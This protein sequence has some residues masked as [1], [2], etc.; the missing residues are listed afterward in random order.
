MVAVVC[1][2]GPMDGLRF[3][4]EQPPQVY[5]RQEDGGV[6]LRD[7]EAADGAVRMSF[8]S[9]ELLARHPVTIGYALDG[10]TL[11]EAAAAVAFL[12]L[13]GH[14]DHAPV[15]ARV[16]RGGRVVGMQSNPRPR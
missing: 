10:S 5:A 11:G 8:V 4:E 3:E 12:R 15:F 1:V 16:G 14:G 7:G 13:F 9:A 2:A 6:Y